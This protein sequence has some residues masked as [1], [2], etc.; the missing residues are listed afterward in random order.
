MRNVILQSIEISKNNM[1][2]Y[3]L[4]FCLIA[5]SL[6]LFTH[7]SKDDDSPSTDASANY[8][9]LT[10]GSNWTYNATE[11]DSDTSSFTLTVTDKD[12]GINNKTYKVLSSSDG[13]ENNYLA[14]IDSNYYRY[15]SFPGIGSIEELYL[16]DNRPLNST[17]TN[18]ASF[19]I[20]ESPVPV[21]LTAD[22]T[23]TVK[24][25]DITHVVSG[26]TYNDVIHINV[27]ISVSSLNF[28]Q[29][30]FYYAKDIGLIENSIRL[31][32]PTQGMYTTNQV[33]VSHD[34]K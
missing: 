2:S 26:K 6:F 10:V 30:D 19:T 33:L 12:T 8:S 29:G 13:L 28:G 34:I 1:K 25:K 7:C 21:P 11:G 4:S 20:P 27:T 16:K 18:T 3:F 17:W 22:L 5:S 23:Y 9:P 15:S 14:K 32:D 31:T 24:E